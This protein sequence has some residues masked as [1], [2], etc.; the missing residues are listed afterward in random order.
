L[1]KQEEQEGKKTQDFFW[2]II[3]L[4]QLRHSTASFNLKGKSN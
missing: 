4:I 2:F 3:F 1:R